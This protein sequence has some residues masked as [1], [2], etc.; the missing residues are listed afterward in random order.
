[1][2]LFLIALLFCLATSSTERQKGTDLA[3][4]RELIVVNSDVPSSHEILQSRNGSLSLI[5][6]PG[7]DGPASVAAFMR[8]TGL[9][10]DAVHIVGHG[11]AGS[12][13]LGASLLSRDSVTLVHGSALSEW[14]EW[15]AP[16]ADVLVYGCNVA[17][18]KGKELLEALSLLVGANV[19]ASFR[20]ELRQQ[21]VWTFRRGGSR[22]SF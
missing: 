6:G 14:R 19:R 9:V 16:G 17:Q 7:D 12:F 22:C 10:F 13:F 1:M 2:I 3:V 5:L 18:G 11:S 20:L 8:S 15:L 21:G 4:E